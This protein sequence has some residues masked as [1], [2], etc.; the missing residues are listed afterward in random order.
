[1]Q[2]FC[3]CIKDHQSVGRSVRFTLLKILVGDPHCV[4]NVCETKD[5]LVSLTR[6]C[7]EGGSLHFDGQNSLSTRRRDGCGCFTEGASVVQLGPTL[8]RSPVL[9]RARIAMA[10][11]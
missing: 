6:E 7:V 9:F 8:A 11:M 5:R 4:G 3:N 10:T 2:D 1:M